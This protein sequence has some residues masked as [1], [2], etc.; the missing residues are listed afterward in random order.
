MAVALTYLPIP[1]MDEQFCPL[2][3]ADF[4]G[5]FDGLLL[6]IKV[7]RGPLCSIALD[8]PPTFGIGDNMMFISHDEFLIVII[9]VK[10]IVKGYAN[11]RYF[12]VEYFSREIVENAL[13]L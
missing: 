3:L 7:T 9:W 4:P 8:V 13:L 6:G 5:S 11:C 10:C 2:V 1:V 12:P